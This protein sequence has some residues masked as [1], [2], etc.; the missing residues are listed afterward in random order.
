LFSTLDHHGLSVREPW[1]M[2]EL[3]AQDQVR[4]AYFHFGV[5]K[6]EYTLPFELAY[7]TFVRFLKQLWTATM[8]EAIPEEVRRPL[9]LLHVPVLTA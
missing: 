4:V 5:Q 6:L 8:P 9:R 2:V 1:V 7:P 3:R